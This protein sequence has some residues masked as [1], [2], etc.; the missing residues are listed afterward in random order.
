MQ[1]LVYPSKK[2]QIELLG[3]V[4]LA[5]ETDAEIGKDIAGHADDLSGSIASKNVG[6]PLAKKRA[7]GASQ[8]KRVQG[9]LS[10]LSGYAHFLCLGYHVYRLSH[11][12]FQRG[13]D[14]LCRDEPF[15]QSPAAEGAGWSQQALILQEARGYAERE[16]KDATRRL[17]SAVFF[18][19][20]S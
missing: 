14:V 19:C 6:G 11:P 7:D 10:A 17:L 4:L 20:I 3:S 13:R 2:E 12:L 18:T 16:K 8:A 9:N 5:S 1:D 15:S